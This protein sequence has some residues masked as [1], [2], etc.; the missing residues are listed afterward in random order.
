MGIDGMYHNW[1]KRSR[2]KESQGEGAPL[3]HL[4]VYHCLD[5]AAVALKILER[6]R[7]MLKK[8]TSLTSINEKTL[9]CLIPFFI[10]LH[11]VGKFSERFQNL[12]ANLFE[13]LRG[14]HSDKGYNVRHD[15]MGAV[16]WRDKLWD[17]FWSLLQEDNLLE[18]R[19]ET[20]KQKWSYLFYAWACPV[21][22]HHGKPAD[23]DEV[24][25]FLFS[26]EDV[27]MATQ[28]AKTAASILLGGS[29]RNE[30][31]TIEYS[32]SQEM[33]NRFKGSSWLLAGLCVLSDWISSNETYFPHCSEPMPL[34]DYW[35]VHALMKAESALSSAGLLPV[36]V[37]EKT[38]MKTLFPKLKPRPLQS[39]VSTC[40][41]VDGAQLFIVEEATGAGK[42]EAAMVL[43]HRLMSAGLAEGLFFAL[44]TMAT[45]NAMYSRIG[46]S[47]RALFAESQNPSLVLAHSARHL[48]KEFRDSIGLEPSNE[49]LSE[50]NE[51][52]EG[53]SAQCA[54]WLADNRKRALLA[55]IGVGT[56]DQALLS[57]LP[58]KH[59]CL[60]LLGLSKDVLIVDEVHACDPYMN[61]LL[62]QLLR[63]QAAMGGCA[64]LLSATLSIK[65][66]Q[67]L[68]D[69]FAEG[70]RMSNERLVRD[71]YPL[72]T[73]VSSKGSLQVPIAADTQSSREVYVEFFNSP[74]KVV[75]HLIEAAKHGERVCWVRNTVDDAVSAYDALV[76][77]VGSDC[78]ILFH[79][80]FA[81]GDRLEIENTVKELFGQKSKRAAG[82]G[83]ILVATQV[84]EQSLNLDFDYMVSDLAP[85][86]AIV[87]RA[88]RLHRFPAEGREKA[89]LG[90]LAPPLSNSPLE[91]WYSA[92]F[93][94][95]AYVY[96]D[97]GLLWLT[98]HLLEQRGSFTMPYDA[99][100]L[101]EG[102]Y[103]DDTLE[104]IPQKLRGGHDETL[105]KD[106]AVVSL[107]QL[108]VLKFFR[109]YSPSAGTTPEQWLSDTKT[110]TRLGGDDTVTVCLARW[111]SGDIKPWAED[112]MFAWEYSMVSVSHRKI[113][114][115]VDFSPSLSSA[116]KRAR[117]K[118]LRGKWYIIVPLVS[119]DG[120]SWRGYA[121]DANAN[122][123]CVIY[124]AMRGLSTEPSDEG[125]SIYG[126]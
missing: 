22:G 112:D 40:E 103:G 15:A 24:L 99:R 102:V 117:E 38:G 48:S 34:E 110:P 43:A 80:R 65:Q 118:M 50:A 60:R 97:H 116:I 73:T 88:G 58:V 115:E 119:E 109:G 44:P 25:E 95:A 86:D 54:Q 39:Y 56:I 47:Y 37:S 63:F 10:S 9:K 55:H 4:L 121:K 92:M 1:G 87:Q 75:E 7:F 30:H 18:L 107:A 64:I 35:R 49:S 105:G 124:D 77:A 19:G 42:T 94:K 28:F 106:R 81:M 5:S 68:A 53:A 78:V 76:E 82:D 33:L 61:T 93:E 72:V 122:M 45:A 27:E 83:K 41:L 36:K 84:V 113:N 29:S 17:L 14:R 71:E 108:N 85:I 69:S 21:M 57:V 67:A 120:G 125:C 123:I 101:I 52:E 114:C 111:D 12:D 11:D 90:V 70:L 3:Y 13:R 31:P 91:D 79:A 96:P 98:A 32:H 8:L 62:C 66:R 20:K 104:R 100:A 59:Q 6:D 74:D 16:L 51:G 89:V 126:A 46:K 2:D 23:T 26:D